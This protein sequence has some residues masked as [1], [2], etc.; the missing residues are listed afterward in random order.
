VLGVCQPARV[1]SG[2]FY[3]YVPIPGERL[4]LAFGDVAGKG[5]SAALVMAAIHSLVRTH[6]PLLG[7]S[8]GDQQVRDAMAAAVSRINRQ[9][10]AST[11]AE[12]FATLFFATC[13]AGGA[14]TYANAGHLPPILIRGGE[15]QRLEVSG[16]VLGIFPETIYDPSQVVLHSGDLLVAFTDGVTEPEND[17]GEEYG[18]ERLIEVLLR[19]ADQPL[20]EIIE[21]VMLE[22]GEWTGGP[23]LQDDMTMLVLRRQ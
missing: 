21:T 11:S 1:V 15:A 22:V 10:H 4:A 7:A 8:E 16:M 9:L 14:L 6:L 5:I 23:S 19:E 3:D 20:S 18:E 12:K 13:T 17:Y 2:D